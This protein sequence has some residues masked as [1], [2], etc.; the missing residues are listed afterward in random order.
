MNPFSLYC[1]IFLWRRGKQSTEQSRA[2]QSRAEQSRAEQSRAEQSRAE[3]SRA[4]QS[5]AKQNRTEHE[6]KWLYFFLS[7]LSLSSYL[8]EVK[9]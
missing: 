6:Q 8:H 7:R 5:K 9:K 2:E 4:E 3:Q 1:F